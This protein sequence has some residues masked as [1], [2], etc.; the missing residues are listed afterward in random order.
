MLPIKSN[1]QNIGTIKNSNLCTEIIE[2][3]DHKEYACCTLASIALG[4]F[5]CKKI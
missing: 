4:S 2:Y 3:S 5:L 1:Q